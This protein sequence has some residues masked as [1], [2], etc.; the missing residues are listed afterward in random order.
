[1]SCNRCYPVAQGIAASG[2]LALT[3]EDG[4]AT[5]GTAGDA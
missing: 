2:E 1:M 5:T 4:Y 3:S